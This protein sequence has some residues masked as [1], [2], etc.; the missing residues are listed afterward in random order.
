M[1]SYCPFRGLGEKSSPS[2]EDFS[3]ICGLEHYGRSSRTVH[4]L[5][6]YLIWITKYR[7]PVFTGPVAALLRELI[8]KI[9]KSRDVRILKGYTCLDPKILLK[10]VLLGF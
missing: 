3:R 7:K 9:Y 8:R 5:K 2:S 4:D 6:Y 10:V 1:N